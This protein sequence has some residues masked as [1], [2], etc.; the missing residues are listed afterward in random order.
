[1]SGFLLALAAGRE[2]KRAADGSLRVICPAQRLLRLRRAAALQEAG[3]AG[4][5]P[6]AA[7]LHLA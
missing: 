1:M 5:Q 7:F 6:A 3:A 4:L 2:L